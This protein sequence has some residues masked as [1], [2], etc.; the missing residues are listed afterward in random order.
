MD[1]V[2]KLKA[3]DLFVADPEKQ[4]G[5]GIIYKAS[6]T[7]SLDVSKTSS[8]ILSFDNI[9]GGGFGDG[10]IVELYGPP[11]A[12]KSTIAIHAMAASQA[13]NEENQVA[14]IDMEHAFDRQYAEN[15]GVD[16]S[17]LYVTQPDC[18]EDGLEILDKAIGSG[19]FDVIVLDSV[20]ALVPRA[21]LAGEMGDSKMGLQARL[22]SQAMRKITAKIGKTNCTVIFINQLREKIGVMFGNPETTTGGNALKFYATQRIDIRKTANSN[23]ITNKDGESIGHQV[24]LKVVKNRLA[25]PFQTTLVKMIYGYGIDPGQNAW[26]IAVELNIIEKKGSWYKYEGSNL[27]QGSAQ[28]WDFIQSNPEFIEEIKEKINNYNTDVVEPEPE[29]T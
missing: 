19:V 24:K 22:M 11:S 20:A 23:N 8:G 5:K 28:V 16:S 10:R 25:A 12:G 18:A 6:S 2:A 7:N 13:K 4:F 27:A 15:L 21:E 1:K 17:R 29:K 3:L 14:F 9:L 26:D